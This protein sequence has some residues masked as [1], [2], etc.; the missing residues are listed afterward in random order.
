MTTKQEYRVRKIMAKWIHKLGL[1]KWTIECHCEDRP[2]AQTDGHWS[3]TCDVEVHWPYST[4]LIRFYMPDVKNIDDDELERKAIHELIHCLVAE[5]TE[6]PKA[7]RYNHEERVVSQLTWMVWWL[8][9]H[10]KA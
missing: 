10:K 9:K 4:A 2:L 6:A 8:D 5:L 3:T 7:D 1:D